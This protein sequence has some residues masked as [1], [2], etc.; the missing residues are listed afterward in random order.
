MISQSRCTQNKP[1]QIIYMYV[2]LIPFFLLI[3]LSPLLPLVIGGKR[4]PFDLL[5]VLLLFREVLSLNDGNLVD[6]EAPCTGAT[7]EE[8]YPEDLMLNFFFVCFLKLG[9]LLS[10]LTFFLSFSLL[11]GI[12]DF[13][14]GR[15]LPLLVD[16]DCKLGLEL[17]FPPLR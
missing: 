7:E 17:L 5:L 9:G 8:P 10:L 4:L 1:L 2:T 6:E 3:H 12:S 16:D 14:L 13:S 11:S 15:L